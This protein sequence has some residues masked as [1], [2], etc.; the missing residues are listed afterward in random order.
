MA[1]TGDKVVAVAS[2]ADTQSTAGT[3]AST[4]YTATLTG[5]TACG[6]A[7]VAPPTGFILVHNSCEQSPGGT[8]YNW[9]DFEIRTGGSVGSGTVFRA[10]SDASAIRAADPNNIRMTATTPITGL[11]PGSTYNVR[12]QF[13]V[14]SGTG[15]FSNKNLSVQPQI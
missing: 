6:F 2:G 10:A 3:T 5:G 14:N 1:L 13:K 7:F 4:S 12:Q 15:T 11:T 9:T 8:I